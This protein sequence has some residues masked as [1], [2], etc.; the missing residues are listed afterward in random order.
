M[1]DKLDEILD[2]LRSQNDINPNRKYNR[3]QKTYVRRPSNKAC[4][5]YEYGD[6]NFENRK[7]CLKKKNTR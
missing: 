4:P 2:L 5:N 6:D 7:R 1:N 3:E